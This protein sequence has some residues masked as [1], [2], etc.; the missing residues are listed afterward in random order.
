MTNPSKFCTCT[1]TSCSFHPTN[2]D[3]GCAP[4]IA[5]NLK[6]DE[7]PTCFFKKAD[8]D[9]NGPGYTAEDYARLVLKND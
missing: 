2:H 3:K 8:L 6:H 1:D 9:Y 4:C 5:K 7:S